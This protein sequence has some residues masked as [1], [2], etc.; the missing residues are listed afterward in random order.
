M[1]FNIFDGEVAKNHFARQYGTNVVTAISFF[2]LTVVRT[3]GARNRIRD[4]E[5][6]TTRTTWEWLFTKV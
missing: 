2:Y 6:P 4:N 3:P 1:Y 5:L